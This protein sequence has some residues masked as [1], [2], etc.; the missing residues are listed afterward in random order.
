MDE[1]MFLAIETRLNDEYEEKLQANL[2][3]N[4]REGWF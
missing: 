2:D 3:S 1:Y 4:L